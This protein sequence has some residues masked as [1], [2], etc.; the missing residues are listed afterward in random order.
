MS[1]AFPGDGDPGPG[2][3]SKKIRGQRSLE[4]LRRGAGI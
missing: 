2:V 3:L 1:P 4:A